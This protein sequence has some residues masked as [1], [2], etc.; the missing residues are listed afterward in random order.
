MKLYIKII[1]IIF[2]F[3]AKNILAAN[4]TIGSGDKTIADYDIYVNENTDVDTI[5]F[6]TNGSLTITDNGNTQKISS[7]EANGDNNGSISFNGD[8]TTL[9]VEGNIADQDQRLS[10]IISNTNDFIINASNLYANKLVINTNSEISGTAIL[11]FNDIIFDSTGNILTLS[12]NINISG[13]IGTDNKGG[14]IEGF[15]TNLTFNGTNSQ[16]VYS[17]IGGDQGRIGDINISSS[18]LNEVNFNKDVTADNINFNNSSKAIFDLSGSLKTLDLSGNVENSNSSDASIINSAGDGSFLLSGSSDQNINAKIGTST[19]RFNI[20]KISNNEQINFSQDSYIKTLNINGAATIRNSA[21][22]DIET[23]N[24]VEDAIFLGSVGKIIKDLNISTGKKLTLQDTINI[25]GDIRGQNNS[26]E[27]IISNLGNINFTGSVVQSVTDVILGGSA[28][29][30]NR[31][32]SIT[33]SNSNNITLNDNIYVSNV[34]LNSDG[35]LDLQSNAII[36]IEGDI[37]RSAAGGIISGSGDVVLSGSAAQNINVNIGQSSQRINKIT[38]SNSIGAI[39]NSDIY[40]TSFQYSGNNLTMMSNSNL[41]ITGNMDLRSKNVNFRLS[42]ANTGGNPFGKIELN[43]NNLT[44]NNSTIFFDYASLTNSALN[45]D[46]NGGI[47]NIINTNNIETLDNIS[48]SDNS[49]LFNHTLNLDGNNIQTIISNDRLVFNESNLGN[50]NFQILSN[51]LQ[52]SNIAADITSISDQ[53]ELKN[54]MESIRLPNNS[55][56]LKHNIVFNNNINNLISQRVRNITLFPKRNRQAFWGDFFASNIIQSGDINKGY[57]GF[58]SAGTGFLVGYDYV[59]GGNL[60]GFS[61]FYSESEVANEN[62]GDFKSTIISNGIS[63]YNKFG[64][65]LT[66]G[67]YNLNSFNYVVNDYQNKRKVKLPNI[68][69]NINSNISGSSMNLRSEI[70][71]HFPLIKSSIFSPK[72]S[73]E[74]FSDNSDAYEETGS[75]F[76]AL[77]VRDKEFSSLVFAVGFDVGG[78][79][80]TDKKTLFSPMLDISYRKYMGNSEQSNTLSFIDNDQYFTIKSHDLESDYINFAINVEY[81]KSIEALHVNPVFNLKYNTMIASGFLS[82]SFAA[83]VSYNF[84]SRLITSRDN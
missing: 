37:T 71:Y 79:F 68:E 10:Q 54:A 62:E 5:I 2:I 59:N 45:F 21:I 66:R 3:Y 47:Y 26:S 8:D 51:A 82:H 72:I 83:E 65:R 1:L 17:V 80:Y 49:Y 40:A 48:V 77:K 19:D 16:E 6:D 27:T 14:I 41:D 30:D 34:I 12:N 42:S 18:L 74:Y 25:T 76:S 63:I 50:S 4:F 36:D 81:S 33:N 29:P 39:L 43:S 13:N 22:M 23:V 73:L 46:Y 7:I 32:A 78:K 31:L 67:F 84:N 20:V 53:S 61:G 56:L 35:N 70:G 69:E 64:S 11:N 58:T 60:L 57:D 15:I 52:S 38:I 9:N 24:I 44:L 75:A 55:A 28:A